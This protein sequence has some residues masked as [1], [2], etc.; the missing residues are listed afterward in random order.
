MIGKENSVKIFGVFDGHGLNGHLVSSFAMGAMAEFLQN[1]K[2]STNIAKLDDDQVQKLI[3]KCFR[4]TQDKIKAQFGHY[5]ISHKAEQKEK[6]EERFGKKM[7]NNV[8]LIPEDPKEEQ[9]DY[10]SDEREFL[11]NVSWDTESDQAD[12]EEDDN[13]IKQYFQDN[14]MNNQEEFNS[15]ASGANEVNPEDQEK[16]F[17]TFYDYKMHTFRKTYCQEN[18]GYIWNKKNRRRE[19]KEQKSLHHGSG[20]LVESKQRSKKHSQPDDSEGSGDGYDFE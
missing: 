5:L 12:A 15:Q 6:D 9:F 18:P 8:D 3:R 10:T 11:D 14:D 16:E 20:D 13:L 17:E 19:R 7:Y 2:K 4:F 1:V